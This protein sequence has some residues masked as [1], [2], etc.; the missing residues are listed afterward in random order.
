M[1]ILPGMNAIVTVPESKIKRLKRKPLFQVS[2]HNPFDFPSVA[3]RGFTVDHGQEVFVGLSASLTDSTESV[4]MMS[5]ERRKCVVKGEP[6]SDY[7]PDGIAIFNGYSR[8]KSN[9][10]STIQQPPVH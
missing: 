5:F 9:T 8:Y 4:K 7:T 6:M 2:V 3:G 10:A 1:A